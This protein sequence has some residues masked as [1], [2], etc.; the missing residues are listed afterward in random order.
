MV[1]FA[2]LSPI[3]PINIGKIVEKKKRERKEQNKRGKELKTER[4][5]NRKTEEEKKKNTEKQRKK[6]EGS[7]PGATA[8]SPLASPPTTAATTG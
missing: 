3:F 4:K 1:V 2:S 7:P 5:K 6:E 8:I